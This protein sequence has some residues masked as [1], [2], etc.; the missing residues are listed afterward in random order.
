MGHDL[1]R[2]QPPEA[3]HPRKGSL[4]RL[5]ILAYL[6][7]AIGLNL[8]LAHLREIPPSTS[9]EAGQ[10]VMTLLLK[11]PLILDD[12]ISWVFFGIG[13]IFSLIAMT[14]GLLFTDPYFG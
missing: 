4:S 13:F 2:S 1:H 8:T 3:V 12:V 7:F 9:L 6:T 10:Q 5:S 14:D 11:T